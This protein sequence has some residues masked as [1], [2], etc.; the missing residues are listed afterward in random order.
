MISNIKNFYHYLI[1]NFPIFFSFIY[2]II[3]LFFLKEISKKKNYKKKILVLNKDRFWNDLEE[4]DKSSELLFIYFEK[5]KIS[6]LT[7]PF[8]KTIRNKIIPATWNYYKDSEFF[9]KYLN[10]HSKFIFYFLKFLKFFINLDLIITPSLWYLQDKAFERGSNFLN[11]KFIYLHKE[12]TL[13]S[14]L[15]RS[16]LK[17]LDA[18]LMKFQKNCQIIVYNNSTKKIILNSKKIDANK[19]FVLGCPRIDPLVKFKNIIPNKITLSS[20]RYN[21]G[22]MLINSEAS[23]QLETDDAN[24]KLFF[25]NVHST[26]I[27][28]AIKFKDHEFIIK[29]KYSHIWNELI[30]KLIIQK[31]KKLNYK[32]NNLKIISREKTMEEILRDTKILIGI[33]SLSLIE[34]RVI[35]IPC[36]VPNFKEISQFENA[37]YFKK[38]MGNELIE[39]KNCEEMFSKIQSYIKLDFKKTFSTYNN[40]FIRQY[41]GFNDGKN[42][43]R[44]VDFLLKN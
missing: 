13:D 37:L 34:A 30:E 43:N 28:L 29:V 40:E 12:N 35:G 15:Y 22:N 20:F 27:D 9:N 39:V 19:I 1:R 44:Y 3:F 18:K 24:L 38:F 41:F 16:N 32:I 7:E 36:I 33:N 5:E 42:T 23:H 14:S 2:A 10:L 4:L 6:L 21:L 25:N 11:M 17:Y 8:V 26:F 31:E